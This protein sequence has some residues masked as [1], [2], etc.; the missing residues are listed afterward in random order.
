MGSRPTRVNGLYQDC[1]GVAPRDARGYARRMGDPAKPRATRADL[2]ALPERVVGELI[3]GVLYTMTRPRPRPARA[4]SII[5]GDLNGP[6][7]RGRGGGPG[8]WWIVVEPGIEL[9]EL[10]VE[11]IAPDVAGWRRERLP[12]LPDGPFTIRPDWVCEVLSP[13]TR[14]H[15][16]KLK[17]PLYARAGVLWM[18]IV[19]VEARLLTASKLHDGQ[20]LE[21]ATWADDDVARIAPFEAVEIQLHDL[22]ADEA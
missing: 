9:A 21:L 15:D 1:T 6:Y 12:R 22:W 4:A 20:W 14:S 7:D 11:E 19:D 5:G 16:L 10:D 13:S 2:D 3:G 18:W 17:R 8:G